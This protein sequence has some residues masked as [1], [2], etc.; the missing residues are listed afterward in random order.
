MQILV[1]Q[2]YFLGVFLYLK[3]FRRHSSRAEDGSSALT[4]AA[5]LRT[6]RVGSGTAIINSVVDGG[7]HD[8]R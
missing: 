4:C 7:Q 2:L 5:R 8:E 3:Y 6:I 1:M